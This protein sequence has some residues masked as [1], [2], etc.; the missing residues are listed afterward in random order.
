ME[1]WKTLI[2]VKNTTTN[3]ID[4]YSISGAIIE[5]HI[6]RKEIKWTKLIFRGERDLPKL[7]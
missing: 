2:I 7:I 4:T 1:L 5:L 6:K 3:S